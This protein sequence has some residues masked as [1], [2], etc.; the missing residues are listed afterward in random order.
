MKKKNNHTK[1]FAFI[2]VQNTEITTLK[3]LG[4]EIDN[5]KL[6]Y[7]LKN[8]WNCQKIFF[9]PGI[10]NGDN[11]RINVFEKL[12]KLGAIVRPQ[13]FL[14]YKNK[15]KVYNIKCSDCGFNNIKIIDMGYSWKCNCDVE[16][17][18]DIL[19]HTDNTE[20]FL[21][22]G[23]GDFEFIIKKIILNGSKVSIVSS[24][25]SNNWSQKRLSLKLKR[26]TENANGLV[27]FLEIDNIKF[28]IM[29][30]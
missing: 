20:I 18:A 10:E 7:F 24:S 30:D 5:Q 19:D 26:L 22:S 29:K 13:Y 3:M 15:D 4:F 8:D 16:L 9:Y 23:D 14:K 25:K 27:K 1:R 6:F 12:K 21:F 11:G 17:T 28:H 2:D